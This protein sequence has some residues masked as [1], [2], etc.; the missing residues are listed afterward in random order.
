[1]CRIIAVECEYNRYGIISDTNGSLYDDAFFFIS[2]DPVSELVIVA[3]S[4]TSP[5]KRS[6]EFLLGTFLL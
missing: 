6:P 1:M 2:A 5:T 4:V 3:E